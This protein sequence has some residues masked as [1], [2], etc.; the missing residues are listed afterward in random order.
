MRHVTSRRSP[1]DKEPQKGTPS[2]VTVGHGDAD[3]PATRPRPREV[4]LVRLLAAILG[5]A[6]L[7]AAPGVRA[8]QMLRLRLKWG[9]VAEVI[10]SG[11]AL[12]LTEQRWRSEATDTPSPGPDGSIPLVAR[13]TL[14]ARDWGGATVLL[15]SLSPT[16]Q[17]RLSRSTRMIL[18][19]LRVPMGRFTPFSQIGLGQ[20]RIDPDLFPAC[21]RDV[22]SAGQLGAGLEIALARSAVV[23]FEADYT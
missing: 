1:H 6:A 3:P 20:W 2:T 16:D 23:A 15:G 13:T 4:R 22:E 19:R 12:L 14:I 11:G 9:E 8:D 18:G 7:L 17:L 10:Q 21:R 5:L